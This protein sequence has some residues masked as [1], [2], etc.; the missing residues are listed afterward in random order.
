VAETTFR[1]RVT[2]GKTGRLRHLSHLEVVHACERAVRRAAL[3]Y[4]VTQGFSPRMKVAFGPAL[5]VGTAGP[6]ESYDLWLKRFVPPAEALEAL[7]GASPMGL[8]PVGA[9]YVPESAPSLGAAL[10]LADYELVVEGPD[11]GPDRLAEA[12]DAVV[13]SGSLEVQHKGK[14]KVYDLSVS[15]PEGVRVDAVGDRA[16]VTLTV[17]MGEWGAMRPEALVR[18][19]IR[20]AAL[21]GAVTSVTRA[22]LRFEQGSD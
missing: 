17:R 16:S 10:V 8:M 3:E 18:E 6:A 11:M 19:A 5:P 13:A 7:R 15:L 20:R 2:Y 12:L 22:G 21:D 4:C 9:E 14:L 1:L